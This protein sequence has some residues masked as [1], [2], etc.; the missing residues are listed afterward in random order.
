MKTRTVSGT[1]SASTENIRIIPNDAGFATTT[2]HRAS[3][4]KRRRSVRWSTSSSTWSRVA[5]S[6]IRRWSEMMLNP[7]SPT[8][9]TAVLTHD[10]ISAA[11]KDPSTV[12]RMRR[13]GR[14]IR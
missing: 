5:G 2:A 13:A 7:G 3:R 6:P 8:S 10:S 9:C 1:R 11:E 4:T 12:E 14:S